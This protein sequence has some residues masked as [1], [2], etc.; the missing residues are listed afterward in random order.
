MSAIADT[1]VKR[2]V[3]LKK[4]KKYCN[5]FYN[6]DVTPF[7]NVIYVL[8]NVFKYTQQGAFDKAKLIHETGKAV[9][10]VSNKSFCDTKHSMVE[11]ELMKLGEEYLEHEVKPLSK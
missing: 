9:V 3:K 5:I 8:I 11:K 2:S 4:P 1:Q 7:E 10:Y 6:N